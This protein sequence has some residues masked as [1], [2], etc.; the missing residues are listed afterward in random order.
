MAANIDL[1][2][3]AILEILRSAQAHDDVDPGEGLRERKKRRL[4]QQIS[5]TAT[6]LFLAHGFEQVTVAQIAATC[7]VSEQTLFNYFPTKESMFLDRSEGSADA[8]LCALRERDGRALTDI[9]LGTL[10]DDVSFRRSQGTDETAALRLF[11]LFCDTAERSPALVAAQN[12]DLM[13]FA[14][15]L[16]GALAERVGAD[17]ED[18]EVQVAATVVIGLVRTKVRATF[19]RV[20]DAT[21]IAALDAAVRTDIE[22]AARFVAP[23]LDAFDDLDPEKSSQHAPR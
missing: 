17:P 8:L 11:R 2:A 15:V 9:I 21:S 23:T 12:A 19:R 5:D 18:P 20:R 13:R 6:A 22:R 7:E 14:T 4:R 16:A 10:L 3:E 1:D